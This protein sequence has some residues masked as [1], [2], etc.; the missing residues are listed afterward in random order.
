MYARTIYAIGDPAQIDHSL[1]GFRTEAPKLLADCPGFRSY[2]LFADREQGKIAMA[3]WWE[4]ERDLTHSDA[5]LAGR[6]N[7][8]LTPFADSVLVGN[9]EVAAFAGSPELSSAGAFRLGRFMIEPGQ[10]DSLVDI[11]KETGLPRMQGLP[12]FCGAAMLI[13]REK[14]TGSVGTLFTDRAGL[15]AARTMQSVARRDA[16]QRTGMRMMCLEEFEVMQMEDA[17]AGP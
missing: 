16:V 6:R 3:S 10:I 5:Q 9:A 13:D 7:E 12:G 2:G 15:A 4:T 1:E 17:P 8:L 11:F 14:G